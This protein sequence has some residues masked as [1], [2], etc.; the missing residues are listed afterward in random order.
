DRA[1][2]VISQGFDLTDEPDRP[3]VAP[4]DASGSEAP[5]RGKCVVR[6]VFIHRPRPSTAETHITWPRRT[7]R[8]EPPPRPPP[9]KPPPHP[10]AGPSYRDA[11]SVPSRRR[12]SV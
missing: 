1:G 6:I 11:R 2:I 4:F 12:R 9:H 10:P 8:G 7:R 5:S 3:G